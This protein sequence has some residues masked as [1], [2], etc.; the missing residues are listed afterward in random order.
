A[1]ATLHAFDDLG[2]AVGTTA[3]LRASRTKSLLA[4]GADDLL[5]LANLAGSCLTSH[6][7]GDLEIGTGEAIMRTSAEA[8][9][10]IFPGPNR[11]LNLRIPRRVMATRMAAP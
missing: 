2:I 11:I 4:D 10:T 1:T 5:I 8:G 3:G 9:W 6:R 7:D